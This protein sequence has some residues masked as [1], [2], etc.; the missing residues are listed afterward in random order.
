MSHVISPF[1]YVYFKTSWEPPPLWKRTGVNNTERNGIVNKASNNVC[2]GHRKRPK[3]K[4]YDEKYTRKAEPHTPTLY[5]KSITK[6]H[7][8]QRH[9]AIAPSDLLLWSAASLLQHLAGVWGGELA[10]LPSEQSRQ[11][12]GLWSKAEIN[13]T[14]NYWVGLSSEC[15]ETEQ[16][17]WLR[18]KNISIRVLL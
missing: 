17:T 14:H 6:P 12:E 10:S 5:Y 4:K 11:V 8:L 1:C 9:Q 2:S 18:A 7:K 3:T 16:R 15:L 13:I